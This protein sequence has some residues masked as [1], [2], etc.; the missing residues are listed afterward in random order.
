MEYNS[1][2]EHNDMIVVAGDYACKI[3]ED[4]QPVSLTQAECNDL[5]LSKESAQLL[6]LCLKEKH[7]LAPGTMFYWY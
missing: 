3:Q 6:G 2:S 1:D 7:L 5:N 4:N